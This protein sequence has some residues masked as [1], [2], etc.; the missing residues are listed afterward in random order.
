MFYLIY[1]EFFY[2]FFNSFDLIINSNQY[3]K[4][5]DFPRELFED[6]AT[7]R[8]HLG[9]IFAEYVKKTTPKKSKK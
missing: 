4:I 8:V 1:L 3:E 2:T 7:R 5:P 9:L 6:E